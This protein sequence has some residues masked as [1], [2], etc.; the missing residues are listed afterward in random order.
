MFW[1]NKN[2]LAAACIFAILRLMDDLDLPQFA[3]VKKWLELMKF[4]RGEGVMISQI[5]AILEQRLPSND[6]LSVIFD[7]VLKKAKINHLPHN[8]EMVK[9]K[10]RGKVYARR[11]IK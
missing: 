7:K 10:R 3:L 2:R 4:K 1:T 11:C 6:E 5:E 8:F 9:F